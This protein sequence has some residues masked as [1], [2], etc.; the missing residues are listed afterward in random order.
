MRVQVDLCVIVECA[1]VHLCSAVLMQ[2]LALCLQYHPGTA[3]GH[4]LCRV[5]AYSDVAHCLL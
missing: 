5:S 2:V 1:C 3:I 4:I